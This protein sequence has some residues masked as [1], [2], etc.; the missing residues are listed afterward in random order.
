MHGLWVKNCVNANAR[1]HHDVEFNFSGSLRRELSEQTNHTEP[2]FFNAPRHTRS[3]PCG[4]VGYPVS[5]F[6]TCTGLPTR[7]RPQ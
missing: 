5:L 4:G 2:H 7:P 6:P 3:R 1:R